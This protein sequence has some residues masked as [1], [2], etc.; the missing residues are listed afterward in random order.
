V[1]LTPNFNETKVGRFTRYG[2][3]LRAMAWFAGWQSPSQPGSKIASAKRVSGGWL[4]RYPGHQWE[5]TA[6]M[7]AARFRTVPGAKWT[8]VPVKLFGNITECDTEVTR[9][10]DQ[11]YADAMAEEAYADAHSGE[12]S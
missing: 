3:P 4:L 9:I 6:D 8:H 5:L 10:A 11:A 7:P 1:T 12:R 2:R